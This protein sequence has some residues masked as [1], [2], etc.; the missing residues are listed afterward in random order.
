M[1]I[2]TEGQVLVVEDDLATLAAYGELLNAL[3]YEAILVDNVPTALRALNEQTSINIILTDLHLPEM[4]GMEL[5]Q[6]VTCR[7]TPLRPLAMIVATGDAS[8]DTAVQ[9]MRYQAS[10]FLAKPVSAASLSAALRRAARLVA[11]Q[12]ARLLVVNA[13]APALAAVSAA[14]VEE[15]AQGGG[16]TDQAKRAD[17]ELRAMVRTLKG[18]SDKRMELFD[19]SLFGDPCWDILLELTSARI[20]GENVPVSSACSA[21]HLPLS[22]ALRHVRKLV[23]LGMVRRWH[24]PNDRRRDLLEVEDATFESLKALLLEARRKIADSCNGPLAPRAA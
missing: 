23:D 15:V 14:A 4:G 20:Q 13:P 24:D 16:L 3:G 18:T 2:H 12:R 19:S 7:F 6:E 1:G 9:A 21:T 17:A 11:E 5:L 8:F 10:D 22:T